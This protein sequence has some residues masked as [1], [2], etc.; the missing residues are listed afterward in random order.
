MASPD[1]RQCPEDSLEV[2]R[3]ASSSSGRRGGSGRAG[4]SNGERRK[5]QS[6]EGTESEHGERY[7]VGVTDLE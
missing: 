6:C 1:S 5:G 4:L 7:L 2:S 3:S